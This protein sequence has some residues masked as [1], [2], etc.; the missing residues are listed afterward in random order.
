MSLYLLS[1]YHLLIR[2]IRI[3]V[4]VASTSLNIPPTILTSPK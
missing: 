2:I 1:I 3:V 4:Y